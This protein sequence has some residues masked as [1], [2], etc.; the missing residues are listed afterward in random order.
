M[1]ER[2]MKEEET[3][4]VKIKAK[5][6]TI[7]WQFSLNTLILSSHKSVQNCIKKI[8][9]N[10]KYFQIVVR[11]FPLLKVRKISTKKNYC[12]S[13]YKVVFSKMYKE[14]NK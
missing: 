2:D 1:N 11:L 13:V 12:L 10:C 8:V 7:D 14:N 5:N 3:H 6:L 4:C 9:R